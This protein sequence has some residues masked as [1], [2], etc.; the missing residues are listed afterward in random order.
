LKER[1]QGKPKKTSTQIKDRQT[2][3]G[4][5][6]KHFIETNLKQNARKK[7]YIQKIKI[8]QT[9]EGKKLHKILRTKVW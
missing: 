5:P 8:F 7:I 9:Y 6:H 4:Q 3:V 2:L 1:K